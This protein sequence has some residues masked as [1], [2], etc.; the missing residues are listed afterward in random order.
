MNRKFPF[1]I[2]ALTLLLVSCGDDDKPTNGNQESVIMP[3]KVGYSWKGTQTEYAP[4]GAPVY[5]AAH[6]TEVVNVSTINNESW[7]I[8]N[9]IIA[10]DTIDPCVMYANRDDGLWIWYTCSD[11]IAGA[12]IMIYKYPAWVG[13]SYTSGN[14]GDVTITVIS[15]DTVITIP[16]G[17]LTAHLYHWQPPGAFTEVVYIYMV[18]D[19][20]MVKWDFYEPGADDELYLK[21][22]WELDELTVN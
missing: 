1:L 13:D 3:L 4:D 10:S 9:Y 8:V 15:T 19:L 11:S 22:K 21:R 16:Y 17:E 20:G 12:P 7:Y 18:P 5:T 14:N 2:I 6:I